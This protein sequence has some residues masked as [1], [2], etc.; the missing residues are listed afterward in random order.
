MAEDKVLRRE[1]FHP[2]QMNDAEYFIRKIFVICIFHRE[3]GSR[4]V[5]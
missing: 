1:Q 3:M 5:A 4:S 2:R